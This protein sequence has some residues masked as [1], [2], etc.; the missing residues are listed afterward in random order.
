MS[1]FM[2]CERAIGL[3]RGNRLIL[4]SPQRS[5]LEALNYDGLLSD[6]AQEEAITCARHFVQVRDRLLSAHPWRFA[7]RWA[8]LARLT[9]PAPGWD[10]A[11]ALPVDCLR[12]LGLVSERTVLVHWEV[13]GSQV[14]CSH[15]PVY[16]R[17]TASVGDTSRWDPSF[18]DAFCA[19][20]ASEMVAA[21][22]GEV[23]AA[24]M[25]EKRSQLAIQE[26]HLSGAI[27]P[28]R[29]LPLESCGWLDYSGWPSSFDEG[30]KLQ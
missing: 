25:L 27:V 7:R 18:A 17:Y 8:P 19:A 5:M 30:G 24:S 23:Q 2:M 10:F 14:L 16:A 13:V 28:V 29:E 11:F 1:V 4:S 3:I 21:V 26:A 15:D 20:L 9:Q 6:R 22:A 12:L